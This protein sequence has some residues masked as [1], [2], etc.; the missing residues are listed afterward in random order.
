MSIA[1]SVLQSQM[2]KQQALPVLHL[3]CCKC[4]RTCVVSVVI[5]HHGILM[6]RRSR[7]HI[8]CRL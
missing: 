4:G 2:G 8:A 1:G 5:D 3:L 6:H 7:R